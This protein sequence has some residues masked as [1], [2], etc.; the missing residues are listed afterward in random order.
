M[1]ALVRCFDT[2][3][4]THTQFEES[5]PEL[6]ILQ[7]WKELRRVAAFVAPNTGV[8]TTL[9]SQHIVRTHQWWQP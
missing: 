8:R 9:Y 3:S 5:C 6:L 7:K 1:V 2:P 4:D